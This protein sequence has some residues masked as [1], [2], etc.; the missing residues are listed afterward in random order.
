MDKENS[1]N[2]IEQAQPAP[3][4]A[5]A[6]SG[7][8][9]A[10]AA[11]KP[12]KQS[13]LD[14]FVSGANKGFKICTTSMLPNLIMAYVVIKILNLTGLLGLIAKVFA[15]IMAVV[16]LP[17]EAATVYF[18]AVLSGVGAAGVAA[19]LFEGGVLTAAH[20]AILYPACAL[21]TGTVQ[22]LGRI[23]GAVDAPSR[24]YWLCVVINLA[25]GYLAMLVMNIF[26]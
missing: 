12:R 1:V 16:G 15:P 22:Y 5:V 7:D 20:A 3:D 11:P 18:S 17:G 13:I 10:A 9:T 26:V 14:A 24:Y 21:M 4:P 23:L 2:V 25:V 19:G 8:G 6:V